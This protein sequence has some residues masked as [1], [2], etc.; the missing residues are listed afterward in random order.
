MTYSWNQAN[1]TMALC[2]GMN[3][4]APWPHIL[5][6]CREYSCEE[7]TRFRRCCR[8]AHGDNFTYLLTVVIR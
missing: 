7:D 8:Y 2:D 1:S 3:H 4:K 6:W 5:H